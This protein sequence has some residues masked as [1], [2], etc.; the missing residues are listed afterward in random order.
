MVKTMLRTILLVC[1]A[2]LPAGVFA[3]VENK[4]PNNLEPI[5]RYELLDK[6]W[7]FIATK[8]PDKIGA[9][10]HYIQFFATLRLS[11]HNPNN[12]NYGT[13]V[14]A[15]RDM[16]DNPRETGTYSLTSDEVGNIILTLKRYKTNT[17]ERYMV[18]MVETNHLTLIRTDDADKCNVIYAIAP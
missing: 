12:I 17:T 8:C 3:Q 16:R 7:D 5:N 2:A 6:T 15:Y 11:V 14:K 18:S 4:P 9:E 13:Y 1:L 10:A